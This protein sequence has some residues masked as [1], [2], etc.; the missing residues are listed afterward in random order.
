MKGY[1][2]IEKCIK[3]SAMLLTS[4]H[5]LVLKQAFP[6]SVVNC[7]DLAGPAL[8]RV[9]RMEIHPPIVSNGWHPPVLKLDDLCLESFELFLHQKRSTS[10]NFSENI[11]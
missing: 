9:A 3:S 1:F 2:E 6:K 7:I 10:L 5:Q 4:N 11:A 8:E